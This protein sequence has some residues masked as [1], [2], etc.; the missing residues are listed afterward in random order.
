MYTLHLDEAAKSP[1][2][3]KFFYM[4]GVVTHGNQ[5]AEAAKGIELIREK[6]GFAKTDKFKYATSSR[7]SHMDTAT[8]ND[9]KSEALS[10]VKELNIQIMVTLIHHRIRNR[11]PKKATVWPM[12]NLIRAFHKEILEPKNTYGN[13][14][15]DR[16]EEGWAYTELARI[17]QGRI[18]W[19]EVEIGFPRIVHYSY[20]S[21]GLS[22]FNSIVDIALGSVF[23]CCENAFKDSPR[24]KEVTE[25]IW[26]KI[27]P[28]M[29][30][31]NT[32]DLVEGTGLI[33]QPR[34]SDV[35]HIPYK[36]DYQRVHDYLYEH[37]FSDANKVE[38]PLPES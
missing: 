25:L 20:T 11:D 19:G 28:C 4:G 10:L 3:H 8:W 16:V 30:R 15:L 13:V 36:L 21:E 7:P 23:L 5:M 1:D 12:E 6:Y 34:I 29:A 32:S 27:Y 9:A 24:S 33:F 37:R 22:H 18:K 31:G 35:G 2:Q 14:C 26:P 17:A 38:T